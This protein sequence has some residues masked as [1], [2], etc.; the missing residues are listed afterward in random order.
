LDRNQYAPDLADQGLRS[1]IMS[2]DAHD[3]RRHEAHR[4]LPEVCRK[5][6]RANEVFAA[7]GVQTTASV[8]ASRLIDDYQKLPGFL[9]A[10]GFSSCTFSYPLTQPGLQLSELQR[11]R[12]GQLQDGR[13]D[14]SL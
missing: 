5:I 12:A 4:A 2:V 13:I 10:L 6:R 8:T 14:R 11:F 7:L 3:A 9:R 1:V